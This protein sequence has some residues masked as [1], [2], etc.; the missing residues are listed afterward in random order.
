LVPYKERHCFHRSWPWWRWL[1]TGLSTL[2]LVLSAFLSWHYLAGGSV[3]GCSV[4]SPCDQVLTS[5]WSAIGG[6]LPVSALAMGAYMAMLA[7]SLFVGPAAEA[8][9]RRLAWGAMLVIVGAIAGSAVW[10]MILQKWVIGAYCPYCMSAHITGLLLAVVVIRQSLMQYDDNPID[11]AASI[12]DVSSNPSQRLVGQLSAVGL[13]IA[14]LAMAGIMAVCQVVC[15]PPAVYQDGQSQD[16]LPVLDP[17]TVPL[18]G[19]ADAPYIVSLLF[20]YNCS[21]CQQ[22][23]FM[24]NEVTRRYGGKLAFALC[25]TPLN[26]QCNPYIVGDA[27]EFKDSC[28]LAKIALSVWL[29]DREAFTV[30]ENWLFSFETGDRWH[31]RGLDDAKI[32]VVELIGQ[33][34]FETA[35]ADPWIDRYMQTSTRIY[36]DTIKGGN[37]AIPKLVFG[38]RWVIP[39]PYDADDLILILQESLGLPNPEL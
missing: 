2:G 30:F 6:V 10:F 20:D 21:H 24:L 13:P 37:S 4:G 17:H 29:A 14:G 23:H 27:D 33:A 28:E 38:S 16:N 19:L 34:K 25:P 26:K 9:V 31:P 7:A 18:I 11:A 12:H 8:S 32:K 35:R 1:L 5:R 15:I 39:Q 3:I 36:G 22:L